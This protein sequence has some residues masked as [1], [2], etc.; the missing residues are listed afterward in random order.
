MERSIENSPEDVALGFIDAWNRH[1]MKAFAALFSAEAHF[2]NVVGI[3]WKNQDEIEAAHAA[4]H[5]TIFK[6]SHLEGE[7]SSVQSIAPEVVAVHVT[8]TLTG[9]L[10]PDGVPAGMREGILLLILT[11]E[12]ARWRI[13]VAQNTDIVHG[14]IVPP[15]R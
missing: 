14:A 6:H 9:A 15:P 8:W 7:V 13:R 3:W 1:D 5:G 2:V 12:E 10:A 4:T 11:I